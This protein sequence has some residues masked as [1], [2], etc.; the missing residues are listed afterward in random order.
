MVRGAN[1]TD[2]FLEA[3]HNGIW[4]AVCDDDWDEDDAEVA[5]RQLGYVSEGRQLCC[6]SVCVLSSYT[7][8]TDAV[9][10]SNVLHD[11]SAGSLHLNNLQCKGNETQLQHCDGVSTSMCSGEAGIT[12]SGERECLLKVVT[13]S[14]LVQVSAMRMP[15]GLLV[16]QAPQR[17]E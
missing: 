13:A 7:D 17:E 6:I 14:A 10:Y 16:D 11:Q 12:C 15:S 2:G 3:C 9:A 5:C 1:Q 8:S 4:M